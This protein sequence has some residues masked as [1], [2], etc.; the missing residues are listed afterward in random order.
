MLDIP[1]HISQ[2][3]RGAARLASGQV[4]W[5]NHRDQ[6]YWLVAA[7]GARP[8]S[9]PSAGGRLI[10]TSHRAAMLGGQVGA[11]YAALRIPSDSDTLERL[12]NPARLLQSK[13]LSDFLPQPVHSDPA[14][15]AAM[16]LMVHAGLLPAIIIGPPSARA[17]SDELILEIK[18]EQNGVFLKRLSESH[19]PLNM[20][21]KTRIV[22]YRDDWGGTHMAMIIDEPKLNDAPIVRMHSACL[23]GDVLG[24]L[25]CDCGDQL[26]AAISDMHNSGGGILLYLDQEG[27]G[28]GLANKLRAYE[29]QDKHDMDTYEANHALGLEADHRTFDI[30]AAVLRDLGVSSVRLLTNNPRKVELLEVE[31]IRVVQRLPLIALPTAHNRVY[32]ASKI[33]K[34]GHIMRPIVPIRPAKSIKKV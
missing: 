28:I 27:R 15:E 2:Q 18:S 5:L 23:T 25:R 26:R 34:G 4:L 33:N 13:I 22:H 17:P 7:E 30:A 12:I 6:Y 11:A 14:V 20:T 32:L 24:S 3:L 8:N 1:S 19:V 9:L 16:E 29:L 10:I 21:E 31:G